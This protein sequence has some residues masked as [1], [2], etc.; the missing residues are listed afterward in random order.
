[1]SCRPTTSF[2]SNS[3][4]ICITFRIKLNNALE[5]KKQK[6]LNEH[7]QEDS[8]DSADEILEHFTPKTDQLPT[9]ESE[10]QS[11]EETCLQSTDGI[12]QQSLECSVKT[13]K[14]EDDE[15][16]DCAI[17]IDLTDEPQRRWH[18]IPSQREKDEKLYFAVGCFGIGVA[19]LFAVRY[20]LKR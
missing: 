12:D 4:I 10:Q 13:A 19:T 7:G 15:Q 2:L 16:E 11:T 5:A 14:V 20:F 8:K 9:N 6:Q 18:R 1:M 17:V 3:A